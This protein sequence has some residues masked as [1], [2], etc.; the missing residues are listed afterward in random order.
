VPG[1]P[2][3]LRLPLPRQPL[4]LRDLRRGHVPC[5]IISK[6]SRISGA[7]L[8]DDHHRDAGMDL[9]EQ[10]ALRRR[11]DAVRQFGEALVQALPEREPVRNGQRHGHRAEA[12][13][14]RVS[15]RAVDAARLDDADL[16]QPVGVLAETNEHCSR[17]HR[18]PFRKRQ[19]FVPLRTLH[20]QIPAHLRSPFLQLVAEQLRGREF[21]DASYT[22]LASQRCAR[23]LQPRRR[24]PNIS[25]V[26]T[27]A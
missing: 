12:R 1:P 10:L 14:L 7:L 8:G 23:S 19:I 13:N 21:G 25:I 5:K 16:Q 20:Y 11:V 22:A 2:F 27:G 3:R 15:D 17:K 6:F 24:L 4:G 9:I 18:A 26:V